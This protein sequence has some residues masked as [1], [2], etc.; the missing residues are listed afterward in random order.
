[1]SLQDTTLSDTSLWRMHGLPVKS[2]CL[3]PSRKNDW[4]LGNWFHP[5]Q[6][7]SWVDT[8]WS[9]YIPFLCCLQG[10]VSLTH[11]E[12]CLRSHAVLSL[13]G[14][15]RWFW[16]TPSLVYPTWHT[17]CSLVPATSLSCALRTGWVEWGEVCVREREWVWVMCVCACVCV[18]LVTL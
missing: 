18:Q 9:H 17:P 1:M 8:H 7:L 3:C 4:W 5:V 10:L 15:W 13:L 11:S 2:F 16:R 12:L 6:C 14:S